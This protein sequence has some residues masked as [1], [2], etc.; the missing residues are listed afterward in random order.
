MS[1]KYFHHLKDGKNNELKKTERFKIYNDIHKY[2]AKIRKSMCVC[3][4]ERER[5]R[6]RQ[7][8]I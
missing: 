4:R 5:E 7:R 8:K 1:A 2:K 3:V 6:E